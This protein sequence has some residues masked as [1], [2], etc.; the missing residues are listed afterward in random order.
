M[1]ESIS[2]NRI[3]SSPSILSEISVQSS[4]SHF[5]LC[6]KLPRCTLLID[7]WH[8]EGWLFSITI[9]ARFDWSINWLIELYDRFPREV[10]IY[11]SFTFS[12]YPPWDFFLYK[13]TAL[14]NLY[15]RNVEMKL[16]SLAGFDLSRQIAKLKTRL[17]EKQLSSALFHVLVSSHRS[18]TDIK[19]FSAVKRTISW[20]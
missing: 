10:T 9:N 16:A 3:K 5:T 19:L 11:L 2:N 8:F 17:G 18:L 6:P 14:Q 13:K 15:Y 4:V 1:E 20:R 7:S 12:W